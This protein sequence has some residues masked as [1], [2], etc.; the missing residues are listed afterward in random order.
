[1]KNRFKDERVTHIPAAAECLQET[2]S[3]LMA[4][5]KARTAGISATA[6]PTSYWAQAE[7]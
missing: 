5:V 2:T 3:N 4:A 7:T 1:M 6:A